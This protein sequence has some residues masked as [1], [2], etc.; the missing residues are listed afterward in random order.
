M[1]RVDPAGFGEALG[2]LAI[3]AA[4]NPL[5]AVQATMS[6]GA[7]NTRAA[8]A[9]LLRGAG[10]DVDGPAELPAKDPRYTDPAW[11][12][13][14]FFYLCRQQHMLLESY[15]AE[16]VD[17]ADLD[18]PT[19]RKAEFAVG[20]LL[21]AT[22]PSNFPWS[23]PA[24]LKK[25]FDTAGHS[26]IRGARN[27]VRDVVTRKGRPRQ[28]TPGKFRPGHEL[29]ATPGKV[30]YR[31]RLIE[32]IQYEPQTD[33]V[34]AVPILCS[35]PWINKYYIMD[36]APGKSLVEWAVQHG[37]TCFMISYRNPDETFADVTMS[38]YLRE[39]PLAAL[40]VVE[41]ITGSP[42]TNV[43]GLC[44]GGTIAAS[45]LA[46]LV[47][48]GDDRVRSLTLL[49]TLLDFQLP[50]QLG[51]FTDEQTIRRMERTTRSKGYLEADSMATTFDLLRARD[52][53]WNYVI[54]DWMLGEEPAPFDM[55]SW[56]SDSAR[57]PAAMHTEYLRALYLENRLAE[58]RL[59]LA[60]QRLDLSRAHQD[61]YCVSAEGDHIAPWKAVYEGAK[62]PGGTVRFMLSNSGHIAGVVNPPSPKSKHWVGEADTLPEDPET[63]RAQ[64]DEVGKSWW[65]D[66]T[67]W[68]AERAG[69]RR[70]PPPTGSTGHP[71]LE[72]APGSYVRQT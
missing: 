69:D 70:A 38:D 5:P 32:L 62:L 56:N 55:L 52:L 48:R 63:W 2:R 54:N 44:L 26:V 10:A 49:N 12:Q 47:A 67:P 27:L 66:W 37:H 25:A 16:L 59:E 33:D 61:I 17:G 45:M 7:G 57:M 60:G 29:A 14:P 71:P 19:R 46:W 4:G 58:G 23:N 50:G 11:T 41:E 15:L 22:A 24:V 6:Y 65:E 51:V 21:D 72:D 36:L 13:N 35:P 18:A 53:V 1:A 8:M 68:I 40:D 28:V 39:G 3:S 20:Q 9:A 64:A 34:H 43:V 42:Q 30:V 31:N